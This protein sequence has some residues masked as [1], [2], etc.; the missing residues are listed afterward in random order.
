MDYEFDPAKDCANIERRGLSLA[1]APLLFERVVAVHDDDRKNYGERRQVAY[2][3][4]N[5]RLYVVVFTDRGR[6]RRIISLSK[7]NWRECDAYC[8][9]HP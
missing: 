1:L 5:G 7:A 9:D 3:L 4:I 6:V 2:G 8:Q